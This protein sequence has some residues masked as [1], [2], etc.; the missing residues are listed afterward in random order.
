MVWLTSAVEVPV[1]M[2]EPT[3]SARDRLRRFVFEPVLP[4][5]LA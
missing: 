5:R 1:V 2:L 3:L 4:V